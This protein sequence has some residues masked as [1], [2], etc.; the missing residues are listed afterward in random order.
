MET[1]YLFDWGNTLMVDD[2]KQQGKMYLWPNVEAIEGA[3]E[4][5]KALSEHH[6]IY[7]ATSAQD[8]KESEIQAAFQR[9]GL[10]PYING[11]FCQSNLGVGKSGKKFY[12]TIA[13]SLDVPCQQLVMVGDSL[14]K[15]IFAS[16]DAGCR[17]IWYNPSKLEND[18]DLVQINHLD[19]LQ[20][21]TA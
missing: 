13:Q 2:P 5:L 12:Q 21:I 17:A 3:H 7:V 19:E 8:S 1:I 16:I 4:A 18:D 14:D 11:Y 20:K 6:T 10:D 9:V 15:D